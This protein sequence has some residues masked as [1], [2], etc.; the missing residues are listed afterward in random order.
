MGSFRCSEIC[1]AGNVIICSHVQHFEK[2]EQPTIT[3]T[4]L[5]LV[6]AVRRER[7]NFML[8]YALQHVALTPNPSHRISH[9]LFT[10]SG[11]TLSVTISWDPK[12]CLPNYT[13]TSQITYLIRLQGT[14][15]LGY[16]LY[17]STFLT[18]SREPCPHS[19]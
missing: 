14:S 17:V 13:I 4:R 10:S 19:Q 15:T 11:S 8:L 1:I 3:V 6:T 16:G 2:S 9:T 7:S 12:L 5:F 18:A